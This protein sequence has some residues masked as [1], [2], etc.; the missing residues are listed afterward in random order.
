VTTQLFGAPIKR[1]EDP[2]LVTGRG[3]YL[4]D[5]GH[6]ALAAA[7]VRSPH[8]HA[9]IVNP[10][11]RAVQQE[12]NRRCR[13]SIAKNRIPLPTRVKGFFFP[14]Q[15]PAPGGCLTVYNAAPRSPVEGPWHAGRNFL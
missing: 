2:R 9:T 8:A 10:M 14:V 12:R 1:K 4:D 7:F 15:T 5:L 13:Q 6:D 11:S 3:R